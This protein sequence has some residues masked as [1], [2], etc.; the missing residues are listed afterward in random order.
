MKKFRV[1]YFGTWGYGRAGLSGLL[2]LP[3]VE[4][5]NVY[6]KWDDTDPN[7][8]LNQVRDL[9]QA[10]GLSIVNSARRE[11]DKDA[12]KASVLRSG[13]VDFILSCC[14]DRFFGAALRNFPKNGALNVHPSLLPKY[15]GVKPLEN[16]MA[17]G[18][19]TI[20]V[21]LHEL[22]KEMDAGDIIL[23]R[24]APV[25]PGH[26]F[27]Q[28]YDLQGTMIRDVLRT[29]FEDPLGH[30]QNKQAQQHEKQTE[31]PRLP[32]AIDDRDTVAEVMRKAEHWKQSQGASQV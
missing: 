18:A 13:E 27:Q 28:L 24:S 23:Q 15:R 4:I 17:D 11:L 20:G 5:C 7:P 8:Y 3:Q 14:F 31:A 1:L 12:F 29:F 19:D 10:H 16:A 30:M 21:T 6:T 32:F 22:V 25:R 2:D 26:T 9:A